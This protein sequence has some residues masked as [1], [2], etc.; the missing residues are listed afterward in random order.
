[1]PLI[2]WQINISK[3]RDGF[4]KPAFGSVRGVQQGEGM[5]PFTI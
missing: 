1:M 4:S 5:L 2:Q 3:N